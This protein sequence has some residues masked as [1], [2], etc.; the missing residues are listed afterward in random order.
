MRQTYKFWWSD[1]YERRFPVGSRLLFES[2]TEPER[3]AV[4][5]DGTH[6][7]Y[8]FCS[9]GENSGVAWPDVKYIGQGH[10]YSIDGVVQEE[11]KR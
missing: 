4:L 10:V 1:E 8:H 5:E 9:R 6:Q 7:R 11:P 2:Y 3:V